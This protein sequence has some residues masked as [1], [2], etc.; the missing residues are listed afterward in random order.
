MAI[1]IDALRIT[2]GVNLLLI[3]ALLSVW[4]RNYIQ[5]RSKHA[6]GLFVFG[7]MLFAE[8][9]L[10]LYFF[11]FDPVLHLW[12]SQQMPVIAQRAIMLIRIFETIALVFLT[13]ITWD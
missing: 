2:I 7:V 8:N 12:F 4:G 11:L 6:L 13:W 5:F 10:A 3:V 9:A 1:W